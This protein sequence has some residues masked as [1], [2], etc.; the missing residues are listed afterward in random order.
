M[1]V[2][3]IGS[4]RFETCKLNGIDPYAHLAVPWTYPAA[5]VLR[6]VA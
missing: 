6:D 2:P 1:A 4:D 3:S 5:T